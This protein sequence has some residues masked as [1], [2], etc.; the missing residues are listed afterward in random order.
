MDS[1]EIKVGDWVRTAAGFEGPV[2]AIDAHGVYVNIGG[3][4]EGCIEISLLGRLT[5]IAPPNHPPTNA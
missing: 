4:K 1:G 2:V 3:G 5:K